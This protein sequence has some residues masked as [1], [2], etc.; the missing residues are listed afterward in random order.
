VTDGLVY[1]H[2]ALL[3]LGGL[4]QATWVNNAAALLGDDPEVVGE[5]RAEIRDQLIGIRDGL[6]RAEL[7]HRFE[8][9]GDFDR[10]PA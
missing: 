10:D 5:P 6:L 1:F 9:G 4:E 3:A 2:R 8:I 7:R